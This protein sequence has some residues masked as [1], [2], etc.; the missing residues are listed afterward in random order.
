M[1]ARMKAFPDGAK[2]AAE[3]PP[4]K[5]AEVLKEVRQKHPDLLDDFRAL[6]QRSLELCAERA[7]LPV[8]SPWI[9]AAVSAKE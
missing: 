8:P 2:I 4:K 9:D 6:R 3:F 1:Y 5:F 7:G